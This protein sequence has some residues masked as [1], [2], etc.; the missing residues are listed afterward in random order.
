MDFAMDLPESTA[1]VYTGILVNVDWLTK[2]AI[3]FSCRKDVDSGELARMRFEQVIGKRVVPANMAT[4]RW[5]EFSSRFWNLV[6]SHLSI[7]HTLSTV[8][9]PLTDGPTEWQNQTI[10]QYSRASSNYEQENSAELLPLAEFAYNNSVHHSTRMTPSWENNTSISQCS[11]SHRKPQEIWGRKYRRTQRHRA[12]MRLTGLSERLCRK[13]WYG[14]RNSLEERTQPSKLG[15]MCGS[16]L[17]TSERLDRQRSS[18]TSAV[19]HI[20]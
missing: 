17:D 4:N 3:Y 20:Q 11:S 7:N 13:P 2:M 14:N 5:K 18:T 12:W 15:T 1:S 16:Q 9:H 10:E 6:C 19:D 8:F